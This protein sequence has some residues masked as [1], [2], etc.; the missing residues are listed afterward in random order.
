MPTLQSRGVWGHLYKEK[1]M[2][3]GAF[4]IG[5]PVRP[6]QV[7]DNGRVNRFVHN[8]LFG[9]LKFTGGESLFPQHDILE[10]SGRP[11][12]RYS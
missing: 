2:I 9:V 1:V 3:V 12:F 5:E 4:T 6:V 7:E 8:L 10:I 11:G